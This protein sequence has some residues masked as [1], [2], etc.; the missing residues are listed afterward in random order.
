MFK[1][2]IKMSLR[3]EANEWPRAS[4]P[5]GATLVL[6][7]VLLPSAAKAQQSGSE[8][9]GESCGNCHVIQPAR[10]QPMSIDGLFT[11]TPMEVRDGGPKRCGSRALR[12]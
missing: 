2:C 7:L 11:H 1:A 6:A 8:V 10:L 4:R 12:P 3:T 9:W 5:A